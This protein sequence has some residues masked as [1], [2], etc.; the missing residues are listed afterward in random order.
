MAVLRIH[1]IG[2]PMRISKILLPMLL[3]TAMSPCP[4]R[5]TA[6]DDSASGMLVPAAR[7]VRPMTGGGMPMTSPSVV[8]IHTMR[9][10]RTMIHDTQR[11]KVR[12]YTFSN[13]GRRQSGMVTQKIVWRGRRKS[14][15]TFHPSP[16]GTSK[17]YAGSLIL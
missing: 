9:T 4:R 7:M 15:M 3:D 17:G 5:A 14:Q 6:I 10:E 12:K 13:V 1:G 11:K 16:S 2:R 8:A